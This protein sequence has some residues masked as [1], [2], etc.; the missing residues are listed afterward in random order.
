MTLFY[1]HVLDINPFIKHGES[2]RSKVI[3]QW[4]GPD[5]SVAILTPKAPPNGNLVWMK[6]S[7]NKE[8]FEG[9]DWK[10]E[11]F[12]MNHKW[13]VFFVD[14]IWN[15]DP[16][17]T[18]GPL[19]SS[20]IAWG[21]VQAAYVASPLRSGSW[22]VRWGKSLR[23]HWKDGQVPVNSSRVTIA[24]NDFDGWIIAIFIYIYI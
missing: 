14:P 19:V 21:S 3:S 6:T 5:F 22:R 16:G 15:D 1:P 23:C 17:R 2:G 24:P 12:G 4:G 8:T 11:K 13:H 20:V 9:K 10:I 18:M 7:W